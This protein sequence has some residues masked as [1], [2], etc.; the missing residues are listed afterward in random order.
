[1]TLPGCQG[2]RDKTRLVSIP[3]LTWLA[4]LVSM[5]GLYGLRTYCEVSIN[6]RQAIHYRISCTRL[7]FTQDRALL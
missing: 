5:R 7:A 6:I 3:D 1:M 4:R 2:L